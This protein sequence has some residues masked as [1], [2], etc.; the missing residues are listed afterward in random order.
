MDKTEY[1]FRDVDRAVLKIFQ[2]LQDRCQTEEGLSEDGEKVFQILEGFLSS[3]RAEPL[4]DG[5]CQ[6]NSPHS[7]QF[8]F[9]IEEGLLT[10]ERL[11]H[12]KTAEKGRKV[13]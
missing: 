4:D 2:F 6:Q 10:P 12:A 7:S 3:D 8:E 5:L 1:T 11:F 13:E 9:T